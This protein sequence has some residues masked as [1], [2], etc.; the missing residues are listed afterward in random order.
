MLRLSNI[1]KAYGSRERPV[2]VLA[3]VS[4]TVDD[5]EF[6][7]VLGPSGSGKSTLLNIVGLLDRP[8]AGEMVL[9]GTT[10]SHDSAQT[11]ARLRNRLLGFVFQSFQLLPRL[12]AWQNI[13]MPLMYRGVPRG[14][15][16]GRALEM[17]ERVGLSERADHLPSQLSGGQCQRV[18]IARALVGEP[19]LI[20][21]DEP[22]GSLDSATAGEMIDLLGALNRELGMTIVM[23]TH[24]RDLAQ[25]CG[26]RIEL[27]DGRVVADSA[28]A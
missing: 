5:G 3:D 21:A 4:L 17:L 18:A 19:R 16:K 25:A 23:V 27:L 12:N 7:A 8:C 13:A 11:T 28:A 2:S 26:R 15:R 22:T 6:C 20:L 9:G 10:I 14:E 1:H 24:D